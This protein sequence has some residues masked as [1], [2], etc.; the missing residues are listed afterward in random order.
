MPC[1]VRA[2]TLIRS[3]LSTH[4]FNVLFWYTPAGCKTETID[5]AQ[6]SQNGSGT[7][8]STL[9]AMYNTEINTSRATVAAHNAVPKL[10]STDVNGADQSR[11]APASMINS[12]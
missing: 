4:T 8:R 12:S 2:G 10:P 3:K 6:S 11:C 5:D 7:L 1:Q 9:G